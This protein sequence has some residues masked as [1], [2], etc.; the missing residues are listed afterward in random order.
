MPSKD[1]PKLLLE[2]I[3]SWMIGGGGRDK[4]YHP[5]TSIFPSLNSIIIILHIFAFDIV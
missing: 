1:P 5:F 3:K 2:A 4:L